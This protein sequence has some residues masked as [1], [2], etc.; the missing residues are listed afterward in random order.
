M[1]RL[2]NSFSDHQKGYD[3]EVA[4]QIPNTQP[5]SCI[6]FGRN[7]GAPREIKGPFILKVAVEISI[8]TVRREW[9]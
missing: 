4:T 3:C 7:K 8:A 9:I 2:R 6:L 1:P 5:K